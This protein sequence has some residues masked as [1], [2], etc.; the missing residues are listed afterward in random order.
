LNVIEV[1][2][3]A[4]RLRDEIAKAV[5]GQRQTIDL[6]LTALLAA[7]HILLEG[8]PGT[9]KDLPGAVLA[10]TLGLDYG[11]IQFTRT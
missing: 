1:K 10:R 5:I 11:R 3:L 6:M 8:P 7:A 9:A 2:D 4:Q